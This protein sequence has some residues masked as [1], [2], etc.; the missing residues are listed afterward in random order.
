MLVEAADQ[1]TVVVDLAVQAAQV[2]VRLVVIQ[3]QALPYQMELFILAV[4]VGVMAT[5][6]LMLTQRVLVVKGS[7][8]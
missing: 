6:V 5:T 7:L 3:A 2:E 1:H 8:S 4:A